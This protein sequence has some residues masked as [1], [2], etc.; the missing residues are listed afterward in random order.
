MTVPPTDRADLLPLFQALC[1]KAGAV[2][3][4]YRAQISDN[5]LEIRKKEEDGGPASPVTAADE[6]AEALILAGLKQAGVDLP[7]I[8]EEAV[9]AGQ[10]PE[11]GARF[12]LVDPLDGTK[13]F[14][15]GGTDFTV[16]IGLI[17]NGA[18]VAG[19]VYAPALAE[20]Y[21][22]A[23]GQGAF[24]Q[25]AD[26]VAAELT[27]VPV[28][29]ATRP[30]PADGWSAVASKSHRTPE[31]DA[32]LARYPVSETVS[33]GSSLKFCLVA[34]GEAD[35]YPRA[36]TTMEWDTAAGDAVLRA[37]GG[38][39]VTTEGQPFRYGRTAD[40]F[41]NPHFIAFGR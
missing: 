22:G 1:L 41:M 39:M 25:M 13:E 20:I 37:A 9:A 33:A 4:K 11:V 23:E 30:A 10:V 27:G 38:R 7:V 15:K 26:A 29:I 21:W 24:R 19:V 18:P 14:I 3:L 16:N 32:I 6:E 36:G 28:A 17:E 2:I 8:A 40:K 31:T 5:A 35:I 34:K 12:L